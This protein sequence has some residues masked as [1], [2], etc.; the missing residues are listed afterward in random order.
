MPE[1]GWQ[2]PFI[3]NL[4]E[5]LQ[6]D[7]DVLG[8]A[9]MGSLANTDASVDRWSDVDLLL[10]VRDGRAGRFFPAVDWMESFGEILAFEQSVRPYTPAT[11]ACYMD[12][13]RID[14]VTVE[15][16]DLLNRSEWFYPV[17]DR[18]LKVLFSRSQRFDA[19]LRRRDPS[20]RPS[21]VFDR[22]TVLR[23]FWFQAQLS[24]RK[25]ARDDLVIA[26]HLLA[27]SLQDYLL[28]IMRERDEA[29]GT[30]EHRTGGPWNAYVEALADVS[31]VSAGDGIL[32]SLR[33]LALRI[34]NLYPAEKR[35]AEAFCRLLDEALENG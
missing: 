10:V 11:R 20:R 4:V 15:E 17:L 31:P 7:Y 16:Q 24:L 29:E 30:T 18:P 8:A 28:L 5:Y 25:V 23:R 19:E 21:G 9:L 33:G 26:A 12:G 14:V 35:R 32:H 1:T 22:T 6:N 3:A 2:Q 13:R 27:A 34:S